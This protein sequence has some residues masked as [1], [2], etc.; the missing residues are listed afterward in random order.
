M[1]MSAIATVETQGGVNNWPR[2]ERSYIPQGHA[3][4]IQGRLLVGT[5]G[6]VTAVALERYKKWGLW[7]AASWS[8]WQIMYHL[9]ADLGYIGAPFSLFDDAV[10]APY[11]IK[12]IERIDKHGA[13]TVR[14][15]A[16]EWNSG[17]YRDANRVPEYTS[18]VEAA[19]NKLKGV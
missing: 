4:T 15:F 16:D 5:G 12:E 17:T 8:R 3:F 6:N 18:M 19:Y 7:S 11:V 1:L 2:V 9:A 10:A 13:Q 14:D